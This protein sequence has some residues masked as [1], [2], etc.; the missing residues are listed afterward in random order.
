MCCFDK[1]K[2]SSGGVAEK[3]SSAYH[4]V[5]AENSNEEAEMSKCKSAVKRIRKM[6][7]DV[8]EACST[9]KDNPKRKSLA[10]ELEEEE[11]L[12]RQCVEKLKSVQGSRTSLVNQ[13]KDAL[14]EQVLLIFSHYFVIYLS[15]FCLLVSGI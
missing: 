10:K 1:Q 11:Y 4:L 6:E 5:V 7:K 8:E 13:L 3:I 12:L 9:G 15:L 14:R 2:V